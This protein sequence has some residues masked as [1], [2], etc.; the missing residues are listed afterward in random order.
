MREKPISVVRR[1]KSKLATVS[2]KGLVVAVFVISS[3]L[4]SGAVAREGAS[5]P[6]VAAMQVR[7]LQTELMVAALSCEARSQYNAFV[8]KFSRQLADNGRLLREHFRKTYG[9][10]AGTRLDAFV[11]RLANAASTISIRNS[12]TFCPNLQAIFRKALNNPD[13]RLSV[14]AAERAVAPAWQRETNLSSAF[15]SAFHPIDGR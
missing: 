4:A 5:S 15:Q 10:K 2:A 13:S 12:R 1:Q 3:V 7:M 6:V 11:T 14:L 8:R 9:A